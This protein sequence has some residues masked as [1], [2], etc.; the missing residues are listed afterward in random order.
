MLA[1]E[2]MKPS[3]DP[4]EKYYIFRSDSTPKTGNR[5]PQQN[6]CHGTVSNELLGGLN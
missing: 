2:K 1:D 4:Y 6:Y 3:G 5:E